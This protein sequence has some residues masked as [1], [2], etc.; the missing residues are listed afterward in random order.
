M[1]RR[2]SLSAVTFLR[3]IIHQ[4]LQVEILTP[5]TQRRLEKVF[6]PFGVKIEP[7]F[8][9][10]KMLIIE[11]FKILQ[12]V[13]IA[14]DGI[15]EVEQADK[16]LILDFLRYTQSYTNIKMFIA[17][18]PEL[19]LSSILGT[20]HVIRISIR[21]LDLP[22]DIRKFIDSQVDDQRRSGWSSACKEALIDQIKDTLA[23]KANGM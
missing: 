23:A 4:L 16:V 20:C 10:M 9:E 8:D 18:E 22:H 21:A 15:N 14:V 12:K 1:T 5:T 17:C 11:L 7:E 3:C 13:V 6:C 2:E 19:D